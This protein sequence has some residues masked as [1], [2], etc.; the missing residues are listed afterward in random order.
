MNK[1]TVLRARLDPV[2]GS[3]QAKTRPVIVVSETATNKLFPVVTVLPLTSRK[4]NAKLY[5]NEALLP[6]GSC[7]LENESIALAYQIRTLDKQRLSHVYG[8]LKDEHIKDAITKAMRRH[9]GI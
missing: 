3:E 1:W 2:I 9:L 5:S 4:A 6:K 8:E 7:G